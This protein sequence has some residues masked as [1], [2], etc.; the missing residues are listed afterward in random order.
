MIPT[1]KI[2]G[3]MLKVSRLSFGTSRLHHI[4]TSGRRQYLLHVAFELGFTHF[5]TAPC[6]GDGL[7]E[8]ELGY[9]LRSQREA[10]VATKVGLYPRWGRSKAATRVWLNKALAK[11]LLGGAQ[12]VQHWSVKMARQSFEASLRALQRDY[13]DVLFLHEPREAAVPVDEFL[14]WFER[15]REAGRIRYWGLAGRLEGF[16]GLVS[17]PVAEILQVQDLPDAVG[18]WRLGRL[19]QFTYGALRA[20]ASKPV[21]EA[22]KGAL[23]RNP[24]GSVIVSSCRVDHLA[25][26]VK[27][28]SELW[29]S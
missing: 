25:D 16:E 23:I 14:S 24:G 13:V 29:T 7:A 11:S 22:L 6:Y 15:L 17:H 8:V 12:V 4:L 5:D 26:L 20:E 28:G 9:F 3:T 2:P 21:G 18:L 19:P 1:T 10:T 27:V